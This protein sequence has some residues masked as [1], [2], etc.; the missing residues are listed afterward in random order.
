MAQGSPSPACSQTSTSASSFQPTSCAFPCWLLGL[1]HN[2][3]VTS[4]MTVLDTLPLPGSHW[5]PLALLAFVS[6]STRAYIF[7]SWMLDEPLPPALPELPG[8]WRAAFPLHTPIG[9]SVHSRY[10]HRNPL[11]FCWVS[12]FLRTCWISGVT[13]SYLGIISYI[14]LEI[15]A[16]LSSA[17]FI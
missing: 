7:S 5:L 1:L 4:P 12:G 6:A 9:Y 8:C 17:Y 10:F 11:C 14:V 2:P 3:A 16:M 15:F 13:G